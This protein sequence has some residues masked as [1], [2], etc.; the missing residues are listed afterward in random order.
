MDFL[1][2]TWRASRE[3][4][5]TELAQIEAENGPAKGEI[6]TIKLIESLQLRIA[7]LDALIGAKRDSRDA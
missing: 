4:L 3:K 2:D 5:K 6:A 1:M 7:E